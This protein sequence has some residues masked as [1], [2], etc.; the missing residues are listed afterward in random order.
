MPETYDDAKARAEKLGYPLSTLVQ[1]D[2]GHWF[3][4]PLGVET[5]AGKR[6]YANYR[7][8]NTDKSLC[9]AVAHMVEKKA[10]AKQ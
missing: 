3:I 5:A 7:E 8:D 2:K 6:A 10:K 1:S 9:A 4:A